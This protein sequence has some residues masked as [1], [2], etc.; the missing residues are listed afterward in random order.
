MFALNRFAA[1]PAAMLL[2]LVNTQL[3]DHFSSLDELAD[4]HDIRISELCA[5]LEAGGYIYV[6]EQNQFKAK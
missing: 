1:L 4:Y 6:A 2:S 5:Y 3:R